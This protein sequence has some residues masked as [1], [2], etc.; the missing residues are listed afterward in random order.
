MRLYLHKAVYFRNSGSVIPEANEICLFLLA[1]SVRTNDS[2]HT[3]SARLSI[4]YR[5]SPSV[6]YCFVTVI[7]MRKPEAAMFAFNLHNIITCVV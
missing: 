6:T 4:D 3:R 2:F 7:T 5:F 1:Y